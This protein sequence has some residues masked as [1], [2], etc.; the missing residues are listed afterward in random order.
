MR[1]FDAVARAVLGLG[2]M[3]PVL[4]GV[5]PA[6]AAVP[7]AVP[8]SG[9]ADEQ[10]TARLASVLERTRPRAGRCSTAGPPRPPYDGSPV[11]RSPHR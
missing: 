6:A 11:T 2:L 4:T 7:D 5:T 8:I 1:V 10:A 9:N 3:A